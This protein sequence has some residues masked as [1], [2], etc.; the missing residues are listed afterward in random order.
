MISQPILQYASPPHAL[1]WSALA[2][3][4][5][6]PMTSPEV[7]AAA[8]VLTSPGMGSV[9][10]ERSAGGG[11]GGEEEEDA[12]QLDEDDSEFNGDIVPPLHMGISP[13]CSMPTDSPQ[14]VANQSQGYSQHTL[15]GSTPP[16][17][18]LISPPD[19]IAAASSPGMPPMLVAAANSPFMF[20]R[21]PVPMPHLSR[22]S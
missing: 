22:S 2:A 13:C 3:S 12:D 9:A 7:L 20:S 1:E 10:S 14:L 17:T 16:T 19:W 11:G 4:C 8:A 21:I 18:G 5:L 6:D 15:W